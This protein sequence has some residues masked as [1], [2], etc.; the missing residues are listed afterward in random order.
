MARVRAHQDHR[1]S[2]R[3]I[4]NRTAVKSRDGRW[5]NQAGRHVGIAPSAV[6]VLAQK[7]KPISKLDQMFGTR[8]GECEP[9]AG[10]Q[11]PRHFGE[12]LGREDADDEINSF[13]PHRPLGP[14]IGDREGNA[15][16]APRSLP[17]RSLRDVEAQADN[18]ARQLRSYSGEVMARPGT[19]I[20]DVPSASR[21]SLDLPDDRRRERV[22]VSRTEELRAVPELQR[23]IP[24]RSRVA[25]PTAQ[26]ID[27]ALAGEIE[28]VAVSADE[29]ACRRGE[30]GF[31]KRAPKQPMAG[32]RLE[33]LHD[34]APAPRTCN[35]S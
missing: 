26:E 13:I 1:A 21:R 16:P 18:R 23:A 25:A 17:R 4:E 3:R 22:E 30:P 34:A 29:C 14:Y 32:P 11:Y 15:R 33:R 2:C 24:A 31:T 9:S 20:H 7:H 28:T 19:G 12:V 27:V 6:F 8:I 5:T 10:P 35:G